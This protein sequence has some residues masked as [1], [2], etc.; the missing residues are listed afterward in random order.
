M[1]G[2]ADYKELRKNRIGNGERQRSG[3]CKPCLQ[4]L[5]LVYQMIGQFS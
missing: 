3:P 5:I 4:Y 1:G 2:K